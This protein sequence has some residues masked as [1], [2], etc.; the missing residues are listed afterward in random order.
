MVGRG[1]GETSDI[2]D[3][4][5]QRRHH[6]VCYG[7]GPSEMGSVSDITECCIRWGT[8]QHQ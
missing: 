6:R 1:G 7:M 8:K 4:A 2:N 5:I 3:G